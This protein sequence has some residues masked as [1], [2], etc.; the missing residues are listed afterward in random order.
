[1]RPGALVS[2]GGEAGPK[3]TWHLRAGEV[4]PGVAG[5]AQAE[6]NPHRRNLKKNR[7]KKTGGGKH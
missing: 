5:K 1:M 2:S 4:S 3:K 7:G 6:E